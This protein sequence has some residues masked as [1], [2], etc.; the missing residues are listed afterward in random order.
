[1]LA[2]GHCTVHPS[3]EA[4]HRCRSC[5]CWLCDRCARTT[6]Q[7]I[8]CSGRCR[9][10]FRLRSIGR[11]IRH[12][13]T[14]PLEGPWVVGL[15]GGLV[16]L[17][18]WG[19]ALLAARLVEVSRPIPPQT[20]IQTFRLVESPRGL[21]VA[22]EGTPGRYAIVI[23]TTGRSNTMTLDGE[24][25]ALLR[26]VHTSTHRQTEPPP[27]SENQ[28]THTPSPSLVPTRIP[29]TPTPPAS[30]PTQPPRPRPTTPPGAPP[31]LHLV[32][33]SGPSIAITF[34]GGA[35]SNRTAELLDLLEELN[36]KAT[37]FL[38]GQFIEKH[39]TLVR[40]AVLDGHEVG[41]HTFSHPHL[42]SWAQNHR[43][44]TLPGITKAVLL[45]ELE[46]SERAFQKATGRPMAP[47][48][49]APYGEENATLRAWALDG[50]YLHVRWSSLEGRSLDSLD[51]VEDEHSGLY[52]DSKKIMN[53]LL[54]F[55]RLE[56]GIVLMH[57]AT[58][59]NEAPWAHLPEFVE[60]LRKRGIEPCK[61]TTLLRQSA[62]W[63]KWVIRAETRH[64]DLWK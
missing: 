46:R 56:G 61:V 13:F 43:H 41:N 17:V 45:A 42:T 34:D 15:V 23:D 14:S 25:K 60:A 6:S 44:R 58:D 7:G 35:S 1:M 30:T 51:W 26:G 28:Q 11:S 37:L 8:F 36:I 16:A 63:K 27:P 38:T 18:I 50:G 48:W 39:P 64:Q 2:T 55:P 12:F 57:L 47:F 22:L 19:V 49:R 53:R 52:R 20:P 9:R 54:A 62:I 33:D 29:P 4:Q 24:G 31:I 21:D 5:G 3:H 59:R 32:T 40:R 10:L